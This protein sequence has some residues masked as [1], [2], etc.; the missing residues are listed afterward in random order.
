[1]VSNIQITFFPNT[2]NSEDFTLRI[3]SC[4]GELFITN[5]IKN[6]WTVM[7]QKYTTECVK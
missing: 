5:P 6:P 4:R 2:N 7:T 3:L 1:M